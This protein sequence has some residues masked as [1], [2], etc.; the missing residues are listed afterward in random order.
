MDTYNFIFGLLPENLDPSEVAETFR[1]YFNNGGTNLSKFLPL[2]EKYQNILTDED[3]LQIYK[4]AIKPEEYRDL[5]DDGITIITV[6]SHH[7]A[8]ER[9]F[10]KKN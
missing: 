1:D 8:V 5:N 4:A 2:W 3:I 7:P 6:L 10:L 9:K